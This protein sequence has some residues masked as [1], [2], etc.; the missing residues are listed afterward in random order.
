MF[1]T[2]SELASLDALMAGSFDRAGDHLSSIISADRRLSAADLARYL[3]GVGHLVVATVT[4]R[5]SRDVRRS[6]AS[7][8]TAGFGSRRVGSR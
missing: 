7:S 4:A 5:G 1:E 8:F 3:V 2:A 6:T